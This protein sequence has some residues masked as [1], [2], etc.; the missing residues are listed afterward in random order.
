MSLYYS[1]LNRSAEFSRSRLI[2]WVFQRLGVPKWGQI[3]VL[4]FFA[5]CFVFY[6]L[7]NS[8]SK[9][10]DTGFTD[11]NQK[12]G[13]T[14]RDLMQKLESTEARLNSRIDGVLQ[15]LVNKVLKGVDHDVSLGRSEDAK[16]KIQM[17]SFLISLAAKNKLKAP[18]N[19]FTDAVLAL[20]D[21]ASAKPTRVV[22]YNLN[23]MRVELATYRS[24]IQQPPKLPSNFEVTREAR[25]VPPP[26]LI[27]LQNLFRWSGPPGGEFLRSLAPGSA[28]IV[29]GA[30]GDGTQTLDNIKWIGTVFVNC[31]IRYRGGF[32]SLQNV[33]FV[34]CTFEVANTP[35]GYEV[36]DLI[37][38]QRPEIIVRAPS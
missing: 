16:A 30:F 1:T 26:P 25:S 17:A 4:V 3:F 10:V 9:K 13:N 27:T 2:A 19:F 6:Q 14:N 32:L 35:K 20:D 23:Q 21:I 8:I 15:D 37:A 24:A 28:T 18:A 29:G 11:T 5:A 12:I 36:A 33:V 7:L 38:L 34:N 31:H 22:L